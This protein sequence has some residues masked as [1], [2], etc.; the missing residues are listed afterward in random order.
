MAFSNTN[1]SLPGY[2]WLTNET[3]ITPVVVQVVQQNPGQHTAYLSSYLYVTYQGSIFSLDGT[4]KWEG[5][6]SPS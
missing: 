6:L 4:E 2:Y 5:P 1:P 3:Y